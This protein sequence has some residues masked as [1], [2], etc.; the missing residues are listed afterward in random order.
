MERSLNSLE[1]KGTRVTHDKGKKSDLKGTTSVR[2]GT[3]V[4]RTVTNTVP[5]APLFTGRLDGILS[6][7]LLTGIDSVLE[8]L[9]DEL[10][11]G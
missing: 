8:A 4:A 5:V 3:T 6:E 1:R 2:A 7:E 9:G 10:D 11:D